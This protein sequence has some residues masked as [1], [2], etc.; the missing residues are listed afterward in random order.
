MWSINEKEAFIDSLR[1]GYPVP[2]FLFSTNSYKGMDRRE[3][4]DG[5]QRLNAVFGFVENEFTIGGYYFDLSSTALT[6]QLLD[7]K[8]LEQKTPVLDRTSCVGIASYELPFSVYDED[9]PDII[10]MESI[11]QGKKSDRQEQLVSS[12]N[13]YEYYL[14]NFGEMYLMKIFCC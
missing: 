14:R 12:Q 11:Y 9:N 10:Q 5:M 4:I 3:I 7:E 2:L 1:N 8:I 13:W 6:K